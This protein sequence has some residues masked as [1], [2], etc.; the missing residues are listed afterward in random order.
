MSTNVYDSFD[1]T[2]S[3]D[4]LTTD[5]ISQN[6]VTDSFSDTIDNLLN[7]KV[8]P[9]ITLTASTSTTVSGQFITYESQTVSLGSQITIGSGESLILDFET[10]SYTLAGDDLIQDLGNSLTFGSN[11]RLFF[12]E[13]TSD[14]LDITFTGTVDVQVEFSNYT[15]GSSISKVQDFNITMNAD[16]K[17]LKNFDELNARGFQISKFDYSL[18]MSKLSTDWA[19]YNNFDSKSKYRIKI[20]ED[21]RS[22]TNTD[23]KYILGCQFN[24]YTRGFTEAELII[25]NLSGKATTII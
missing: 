12:I 22:G 7:E 4:T 15:S 16:Q 8:Y 19:L 10:Q 13:D 24:N 25:S 5:S 1:A 14:T 18:S 9:K 17:E 2:V 21:N 3:F 11:D 6:S 20:L 23:T